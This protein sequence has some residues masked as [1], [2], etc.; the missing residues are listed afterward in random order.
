MKWYTDLHGRHDTWA[1]TGRKIN[2]I[3]YEKKVKINLK[4]NVVLLCFLL[5]IN[6][7]KSRNWLT[8]IT[9]KD[10]IGLQ[11]AEIRGLRLQGVSE[12]VSASYQL[13]ASLST[14]ARELSP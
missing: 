2:K 3:L 7:G 6:L 8:H 12:L 10:Q 5:K 13:S 1:E 9:G 4:I 11:K 14:A